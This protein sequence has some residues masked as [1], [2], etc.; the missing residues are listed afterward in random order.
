MFLLLAVSCTARKH[1]PST[2]KNNASAEKQRKEYAEKTGIEIP[3]DYNAALIAYLVEWLG[4]PYHYG[5]DSKSGT[6][7]SGFTKNVYKDVYGKALSRSSNDQYQQCK[8]ISASKLKEGD[9]VFFKINTKKVGHVGLYLYNNYFIHASTKRGV[10]IS[11]LDET[12][13]KKYFFAA[14]RLE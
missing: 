5:G 11:N 14:G 10:M 12:Y 2:V 7:C 1:T 6:D 9:L 8:E 13:Y 3:A 4:V